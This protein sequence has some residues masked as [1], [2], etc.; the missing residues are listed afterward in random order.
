M[1]QVLVPKPVPA[2]QR[3]QFESDVAEFLFGVDRP[4]ADVLEQL[5]KRGVNL[6]AFAE[7]LSRQQPA[8]CV[9]PDALAFIPGPA[10]MKAA[11]SSRFASRKAGPSGLSST[12]AK[13]AAQTTRQ[14][15]CMSNFRFPRDSDNTCPIRRREN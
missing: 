10:L 8:V 14:T 4:R 12:I 3:G 1:V 15:N 2:D 11:A 6:N 13:R 7:S 9:E 5:E